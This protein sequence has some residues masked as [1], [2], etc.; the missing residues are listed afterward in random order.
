MMS[1]RENLERPLLSV[2]GLKVAFKTKKGMAYAVDDVTFDVYKGEVFGLAGESGSGKSTIALSILR[3]IEEPGRIEAGS[4]IFDGKNVL[5]FTQKELQEYRWHD[6]S[7]VFQGAMNSFNPVMRIGEQLVDAI[8]AHSNMTEEEAYKRAEELIAMVG[9]DKMFIN[10]YP[11]ELSGGMKQRAM[12]AMALVLNPK[13]LIA[14]EPTTSIDVIR[15]V[16]VLRL[17]K[18]LQNKLGLSMIYITHDLSLMA[19]IADRVGIMYAGKLVEQGTVTQIYKT[20]AHPYTKLLLESIPKLDDKGQRLAGIPGQP[21]NPMSYPSGCR[22]HNRCPFA[23]NICSRELP[24]LRELGSIWPEELQPS[25]VNT[26][27]SG[28]YVACHLWDKARA[29]PNDTRYQPLSPLQKEAQ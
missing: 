8:M 3:L 7:M 14:D 16:E 26:P 2:K 28:H 27:Q 23:M 4:I 9:I 29:G 24:E 6:V 21:P 20:P 10:R 12:I 19:A 15:Q 22:F 11:F 18:G 13:L 17:L 25:A 5:E 1:D